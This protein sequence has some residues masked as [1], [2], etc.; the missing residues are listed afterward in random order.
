MRAHYE[1]NLDIVKHVID[2]LDLD[3]LAVTET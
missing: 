2:D 3:I 1:K